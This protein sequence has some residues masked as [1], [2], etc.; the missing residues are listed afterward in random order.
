MLSCGAWKNVKEALGQGSKWEL[1]IQ[2]WS[3][4]RTSMSESHGAE[5]NPVRQ[6]N[7]WSEMLD[8]CQGV[9]EKGKL[10]TRET[11]EMLNLKMMLGIMDVFCP[12]GSQTW[13]RAAFRRKL[14]GRKRNAMC[15]GERFLVVGLLLICFGTCMSSIPRGLYLIIYSCIFVGATGLTSALRKGEREQ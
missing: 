9:W 15:N 1:F 14:M 13:K 12:V 11:N 2:G 4:D 5:R 3:K 6:E 7:L 10:E 8:R